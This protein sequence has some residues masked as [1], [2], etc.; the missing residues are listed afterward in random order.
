MV[1]IFSLSHSS[2]TINYFFRSS[3]CQVWKWYIY[4]GQ[5]Y[6]II[7]WKDWYDFS[8]NVFI[9]KNEV[10]LLF[11]GT[12]KRNNYNFNL[13]IL[14]VVGSI[15]LSISTWFLIVSSE[16]INSFNKHVEL[17][18]I[19]IFYNVNNIAVS[20]SNSIITDEDF[21]LVKHL[22]SLISYHHCLCS[23]HTNPLALMV[24]HL[25]HQYYDIKLKNLI[26]VKKLF[27]LNS[28]SISLFKILL[29]KI[30]YQNIF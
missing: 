21:A 22:S 5:E 6:N 3:S 20:T 7:F 18:N 15:G 23:F 17:K 26:Y 2:H 10:I 28:R 11:N 13:F 9:S 30:N 24:R 4:W 25:Y 14:I 19:L 8:T 1:K 29:I 12:H 16:K 27:L